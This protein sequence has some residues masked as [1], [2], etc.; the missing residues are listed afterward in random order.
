MHGAA[1]A[2]AV[3]LM[4]MPTGPDRAA[5][6]DADKV[7]AGVQEGEGKAV[8][9]EADS[10]EVKQEQKQAVFTGNVDAK[11][12]NVH[13]TSDELVVDYAVIKKGEKKRN[14]VTHLDARG[15]VI[16]VS[17]GQTVKAEWAK[18][19]MQANTVV[20]GDKVTVT[21]GKSVI[22]GKRLEMNLTT[23]K[24]KIIGGRVRGTFFQ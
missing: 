2:A 6:Q 20:M 23:G 24:S 18:M 13:L 9:I 11:K 4:L 14:E 15:N 21:E 1:L 8:E 22:H 16:V 3:A 17:K 19:D 5:A 12:G 7:V 10:M